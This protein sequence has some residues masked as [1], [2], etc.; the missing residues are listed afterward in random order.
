MA[1]SKPSDSEQVD[2]LITKLGDEVKATV[3]TIRALILATDPEIA[4]QVKWN[5]PSFYFT[6]EMKPFDPK[7]Y[8]R[9]IVVCNIH[10][11][12]ILLVFPT[13][14]KVTSSLKGKDYPDGRKIVTIDDLT[15]TTTNQLQQLIKDWL[16]MVEK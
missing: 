3:Q 5:S 12:K 4:E 9:D 8:K 13:G 7:E 10:R 6:G 15:V 2:E 1:K 11:G 14:A 16:G